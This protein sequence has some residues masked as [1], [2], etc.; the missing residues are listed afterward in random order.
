M[1]ELVAEARTLAGLGVKEIVLVGQDT[2]Y[3][4]YDKFGRSLLP[5]LIGAITTIPG[6][7]WIRVM[8]LHPA[9]I[10]DALLTVLRENHKVCRYLDIPIQHASDRVL[11]SMR[12]KVSKSYLS[13]LLSRLKSLGFT[14][15]TTVLVGFPGETEADFMELCRFVEDIG[16]EH[17]GVFS[18]SPEEETDAAS[19][20][21]RLNPEVVRRRAEELMW[22][23]HS[24]TDR[25]NRLFLSKKVKVLIDG[26]GIGRREFDAPEI[27]SVVEVDSDRVGTFVEV[28][29][30]SVQ[31]WRLRGRVCR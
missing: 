24:L 2:G 7:E 15:R 19:L 4:G 10:D 5:D 18:Y 14:L 22:I 17:L 16:F 30:D 13:N 27:D 26:V 11:R 21:E 31:G 3:Y 20:P 23:S 29:I 8:Y 28:A 12:R 25:F 1:D 6:I 9:H